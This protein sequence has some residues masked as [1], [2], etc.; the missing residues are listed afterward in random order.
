M[1]METRIMDKEAHEVLL[2][3]KRN[4]LICGIIKAVIK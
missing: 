3:Q 1:Q 2:F 4:F